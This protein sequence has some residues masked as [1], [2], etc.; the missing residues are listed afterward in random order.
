MIKKQTYTM[1]LSGTNYEIGYKLGQIARDNAL[2]KQKLAS[3]FPDF[4]RDEAKQ[5]NEMF[6]KYCPGLVEELQGFADAI[7]LQLEQITYYAMTYLQPRCSQIAVLP[8]ITKNKHPLIARNYE[9]NYEVE[10]FQLLK[11][12]VQ[13]KYTHLGTSVLQFGRDDGFNEHGLVVTMSSCGIPVGAVPAMRSP[14]VT[15]LQFWAVIRSILENC[16][17][18]QEA[19]QFVK[20][21][22]IA[23]NINLII[24]D[25]EGNAALL[26]TLDGQMAYKQLNSNS[27]ENYIFATNHP[28]LPEMIAKEPHAMHNSLQRYKY[29][30]ETLKDAKDI[31][32]DNLKTLLLNK[33]PNG[34]CCHYYEDFFGTVKSMVI[35]PIDGKIHLC[36]GGRKEN[37]WNCYDI[38]KTLN[39]EA[40]EIELNLERATPALFE[41][42]P[43]E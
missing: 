19:L 10:D 35:D 13:G 4:G 11:T 5:A 1:E 2:L 8:G 42:E 43:I 22:P 30:N 12:S 23:Y 16:K 37:G 15:G 41:F 34:L 9:F 21:I 26:E 20:D 31:T 40:K 28:L 38:N 39:S 33:Y 7:K 18:V 27:N 36:W 25:K 14:K 24:T 29:I 3:G 32:V 17:N 6:A